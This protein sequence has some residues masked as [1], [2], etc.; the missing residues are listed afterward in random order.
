M[1]EIR[2]RGK[3]LENGHGFWVYGDLMT[4]Y[5]HHEGLTIVEHGC[6]YYEVDP[7]T[8]GQFTSLKDKHGKEIFEGDV[9]K[10]PY[11][12]RLMVIR[13]GE[14][15]NDDILD[16]ID[17]FYIDTDG[18]ERKSVGFYAE[19]MS[20]NRCYELDDGVC[21]WVEVIGNIHDNPEL[22]NA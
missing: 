10:S 20:D 18:D 5:V 2:F 22:L 11:T 17:D 15:Q 21:K 6:I 12:N 14:Y 4:E 13:W 3:R 8:V 1:R 19:V 16:E 7:A 9:A